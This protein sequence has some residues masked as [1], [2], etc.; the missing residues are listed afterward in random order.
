M[1]AAS[2]P[3]LPRWRAALNNTGAL[4]QPLEDMKLVGDDV[5]R[6]VRELALPQLRQA[7]SVVGDP[8][9]FGTLTPAAP[10]ELGAQERAKDMRILG[11]GDIG[12]EQ[13]GGRGVFPVRKNF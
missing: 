5:K 7:V 2:A 11:A 4:A 12:L 13:F 6:D 8:D 10:V 9:H 3:R 1:K